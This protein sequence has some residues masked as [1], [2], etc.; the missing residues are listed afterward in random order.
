MSL[1]FE[2]SF[3]NTKTNLMFRLFSKTV[4]LIKHKDWGCKSY[5]LVALQAEH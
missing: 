2:T 4:D 3:H 1:A 5:A